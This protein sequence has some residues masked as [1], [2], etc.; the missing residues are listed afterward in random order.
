MTTIL[1]YGEW[2][3]DRGVHW[4]FEDEVNTQ[5]YKEQGM[6]ANL[7]LSVMKQYN[8]K[9]FQHLPTSAYPREGTP[10]M[11]NEYDEQKGLDW[12]WLAKN[13]IRGTDIHTGEVAGTNELQ[14]NPTKRPKAV[15][16]STVQQKHGRFGGIYYNGFDAE[17]NYGKDKGITPST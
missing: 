17:E 16:A 4:R 2:N 13:R 8:I 3:N 11:Y 6:R 14:M 15:P 7:Q 10:K 9:D 5:K 12:D 1:A